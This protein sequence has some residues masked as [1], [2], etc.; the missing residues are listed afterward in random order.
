MNKIR[1]FR[2]KNNM[3]QSDLATKLNLSRTTITKWEN[4]TT[5]PKLRMLPKIA[6]ALN[7][8]VQDLICK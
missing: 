4:N 7:C 8:T 6:E 2:L 3:K 1:Y 5:N